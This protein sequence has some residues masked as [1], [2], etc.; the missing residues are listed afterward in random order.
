VN[1]SNPNAPTPLTVHGE[2]TEEALSRRRAMQWVLSAVA[3]S[4]V[5]SRFASG[6]EKVPI[7]ASSRPSDRTTP[8]Q[9]GSFDQNKPGGHVPGGYGVDPV[10]NKAHKPGEF[11]PLTFDANQKKLATALADT[12]I[13]KDKWG[14]A[15]SE[16]GVVAMID[17]WIS[18][19]Y[20]DQKADRPI[21]L[22]GMKWLEAESQKRFTKNF[23][24]LDETQKHAICDDIC[25][26][27]KAKEEFK[28]GA[29]FFNKFRDLAASA[30]YATPAG[31][32]AVG[33]V[34]NTMLKTF[35]GPPPEVLKRLGIEIAEKE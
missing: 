24:D 33:Y 10:L 30:Y 8:H 27:A 4:Q 35:D 12:I 23:A 11:W 18:A 9:E 26:T 31:W 1:D 28:A 19:P 3:A 29:V 13:P 14:P 7:P 16:L 22:D 5:P 20:D 32:Q 2:P 21:I 34:G 25:F 17:E 6:Q 15:A